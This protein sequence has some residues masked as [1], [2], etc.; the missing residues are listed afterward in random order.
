MANA[1]ATQVNGV[2]TITTPAS[3]SSMILI[4]STSGNAQWTNFCSWSDESQPTSELLGEW[5]AQLSTISIIPSLDYPGLISPTTYHGTISANTDP[6][7][8]GTTKTSLE[9]THQVNSSSPIVPNDLSVTV[10]N[11]TSNL[12]VITI[13]SEDTGDKN[14]LDFNMTLIIT[15]SPS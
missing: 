12:T 13:L 11:V 6:V 15:D 10:M 4:P 5:S 8:K 14:Y 1:T 9:F 3:L 7:A 2:C